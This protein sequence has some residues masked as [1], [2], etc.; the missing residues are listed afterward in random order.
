MRLLLTVLLA[1][2]SPLSAEELRTLTLKPGETALLSQPHHWN[3]N[4]E[5]KKPE[6]TINDM[7]AFGQLEVR[8]GMYAIGDFG[9]FSQIGPD[10]EGNL[11]PCTGQLIYGIQIFYTADPY[12]TGIDPLSF[13]AAFE[14]RGAR[15]VKYEILIE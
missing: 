3:R 7:P 10:E 13:T 5:T 14:G 6:I 9:P 11:P 1:L 4:C 8:H 12:A 2:T 15:T